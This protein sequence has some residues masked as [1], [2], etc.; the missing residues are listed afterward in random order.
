[1][2]MTQLNIP[3]IKDLNTQIQK[4]IG[5]YNPDLAR[6]WERS[7]GV[8]QAG[9]VLAG[10]AGIIGSIAYIAN[11][12]DPMMKTPAGQDT[13]LGK[14]S[15]KVEK[16]KTESSSKKTESEKT[17]QNTPAESAAEAEANTDAEAATAPSEE[18]VDA[19]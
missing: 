10:L 15:S 16:A 7:G 4:Q 8:L 6:A 12:C 19:Q 11:Q 2:V 9:A 5:I 18:L 3:G 17:E 14:L 1:M 13:D